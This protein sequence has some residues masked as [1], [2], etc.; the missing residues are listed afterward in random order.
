MNLEKYKTNV[1]MLLRSGGLAV[2]P[3]SQ[4]KDRNT[5]KKYGFGINVLRNVTK[6]LTFNMNPIRA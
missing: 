6:A 4:V 3:T 5:L 2:W 1:L